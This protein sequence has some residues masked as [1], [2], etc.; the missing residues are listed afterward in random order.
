MAQVV[1]TVDLD[2]PVSSAYRQ[3][4]QFESFGEFLSF[5]DSVTQIDA[6]HDHWVVTIAGAT[7]EFD[8]E[9]A[10]QIED[11]RIAWNSVSGTVDHAGVVTFHRVSDTTSRVAV[12]IDWE[13]EGFVEKAGAALD[14]PDRAVA[15]ALG[16]FKKHVESRDAI[17]DPDLHA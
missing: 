3:W 6:T 12:Q 2:V 9:I 15:G 11:N 1:E 16:D 17:A 13:P 4:E 8:T 14:I 10:E 5:V 7:R